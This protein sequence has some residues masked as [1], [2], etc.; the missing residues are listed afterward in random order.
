VADK[1]KYTLHEGD[2]Y[3]QIISSAGMALTARYPDADDIDEAE[4]MVK[5]LNE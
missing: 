3:L 1:P 2:D 5:R 4:E